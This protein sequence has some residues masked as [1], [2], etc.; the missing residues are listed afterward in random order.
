MRLIRRAVWFLPG[1]GFIAA[2]LV[3]IQV[4]VTHGNVSPVL[5]PP[6]SSIAATLGELILRGDFMAPLLSTIG[7]FVLSFGLSVA[8]GLGLG[9]A[10]GT[11]QVCRNL[12][13]PLVELVRPMPKPALLPMLMLFLGIGLLMKTTVIVL[14]GL[15]PVLI[16]TLQGVIGVDPVLTGTGR[17][18]GLSRGALI[19]KVILPAAM[20]YAM[21]GIRISLGLCLLVTVLAEMLTATSGLGFSILQAERT[22]RIGHMYAWLVVLAVLG[23]VVNYAITYI[24]KRLTPW[25]H[26]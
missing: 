3:L 10:M 7:L 5:L 9:I 14:T 13:E 6:P 17:T 2:L 11:S 23:I 1:I 26:L 22:F 15:F 20:P 18:F 4:L 16:N 21:S 8:I 24:E 25:L 19:R 12:L